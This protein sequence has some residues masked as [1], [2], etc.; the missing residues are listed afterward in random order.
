MCLE[1]KP[2]RCYIAT[3]RALVRVSCCMAATMHVEQC[4]VT[5]HCTTCAD[6][7][8]L[9]LTQISQNL[10]IGEVR[11][12]VH[13]MCIRAK[14]TANSAL[15]LRHFFARLSLSYLRTNI[16]NNYFTLWQ[17]NYMCWFIA[18]FSINITM[19]TCTLKKLLLNWSTISSFVISSIGTGFDLVTLG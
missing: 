17:Y 18:S 4:A 9:P 5:K 1:V 6:E 7:H 12:Q 19:S 15:G 2:V 8:R 11:Q 13:E 3:K 14:T 10:V 16:Y